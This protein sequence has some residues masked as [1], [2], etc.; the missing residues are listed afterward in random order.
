M[1]VW[2]FSRAEF[3]FFSFTKM[4]WIY[5][6]IFKLEKEKKKEEKKKLKT[7]TQALR[8]ILCIYKDFKKKKVIHNFLFHLMA[9]HLS[10]VENNPT[11]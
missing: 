7:H 5:G 9:G 6:T 11:V 4:I 2:L 10:Q 3:I 1:D 8:I